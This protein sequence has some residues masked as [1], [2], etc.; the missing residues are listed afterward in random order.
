[1]P[2]VLTAQQ[3][4]ALLL[5]F[6]PDRD[7]AGVRYLELRSRLMTVFRYRGC[8]NPEEL[9]DEAMDRVARK[10][11]E[12][13]PAD[14]DP[15]ALLFG[16]AWNVARESFHRARAV[17]LPDDWDVPDPHGPFQVDDGPDRGQECLER[18]LGR[19]QE[20]DRALVLT[21]FEREKRAKIAHRLGIAR[22]LGISANALRLK[23]HRITQQLRLCVSGCMAGAATARM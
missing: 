15:R 9:A 18:C 14:G 19:L 20:R 8:A 10:L 13:P 1:M 12:A 21:Y 7:T 17:A 6:S 16:V 22:Q 23:I 5:R 3:F 4:D 11:L 2:S